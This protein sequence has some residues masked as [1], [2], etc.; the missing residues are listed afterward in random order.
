LIGLSKNIKNPELDS[1]LVN[2]FF[3]SKKNYSNQS[4]WISGLNWVFKN[5]DW[6]EY[7]GFRYDYNPDMDRYG[8][9]YSLSNI[10]LW[11]WRNSVETNYSAILE[12]IKEC[13]LSLNSS[14]QINVENLTKDFLTYSGKLLRYIH[15]NFD[16]V[17]GTKGVTSLSRKLQITTAKTWYE[18]KFSE[19]SF[20][21]SL[22]K[23][24][25]VFIPKN[26]GNGDDYR[27]GLDFVIDDLRC[28]H[29]KCQIIE[30]EDSY[31]IFSNN[32]H[33]E[34]HKTLNWLVVEY[35]VS[36]Y[37]F[38]IN[39]IFDQRIISSY[40]SITVPKERLVFKE[41]TPKDELTEILNQ[42]FSLSIGSGYI[43]EMIDSEEPSVETDLTNKSV[44]IKFSGVDLES[45][46]ERLRDCL[47]ELTNVL[48]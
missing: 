22:Y 25:N 10:E 45:I 28:Q 37:V 41:E 31:E 6:S 32:L 12:I 2:Y 18:S 33:K 14:E 36:V 35:G 20:I 44:I 34:K 8:V 17:F 26:R 9:Y 23:D 1:K 19:I 13:N 21:R 11:S 7:D 30:R 40:E 43:F 42:I 39:D 5:K 24:S 3:L 48:Y 15:Y 38:D 47:S 16:Y 46:E 4:H 29:K 27:Y